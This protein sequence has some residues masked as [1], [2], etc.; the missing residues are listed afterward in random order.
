MA[1]LHEGGKRAD[2]DV[3]AGIWENHH[4]RMLSEP[5]FT[6][7]Q[8]GRNFDSVRLSGGV[9][10][11]YNTPIPQ[12][13]DR[14]SKQR[15]NA[16]GQLNRF[17]GMTHFLIVLD[18]TKNDLEIQETANM[19]LTLFRV[20]PAVSFD[21]AYLGGHDDCEAQEIVR[22][23]KEKNPS[24]AIDIL[25]ANDARDAPLL[26]VRKIKQRMERA[27]HQAVP[28]AQK[29]DAFGEAYRSMTR[30]SLG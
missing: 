17:G 29:R 13:I 7:E 22:R 9:G 28:D 26:L 6:E 3:Y 24:A 20:G 27:S 4:V 18:G 14:L 19:L 5:T 12:I 23:V 30:V 15:T 10:T 16:Q 11:I 2:L 21:I 1:I 8:I 25:E